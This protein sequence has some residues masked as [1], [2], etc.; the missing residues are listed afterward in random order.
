M[1]FCKPN[2]CGL[3][4]RYWKSIEERTTTVNWLEIQGNDG[5]YHGKIV[6]RYP[7][8]HGIVD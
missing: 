8:L 7:S 1:L 3:H 6:Y 5:R 2:N 4:Q